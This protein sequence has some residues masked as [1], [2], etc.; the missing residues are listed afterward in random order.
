MENLNYVVENWSQMAVILA[1]IFAPISYFIKRYF[2]FKTKKD[3]ISY[4]LYVNKK[5]ALIDNFTKSSLELERA[6]SHININKVKN[7]LISAD[8]L[9]EEIS[10]PLVEFKKSYS[11]LFLILKKEQM[12][13][14]DLINGNLLD[15]NRFIMDVYLGVNRNREA[16]ISD[17]FFTLTNDGRKFNLEYYSE[18]G[19]SLNLFGL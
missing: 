15:I 18:I 11:M 19:K 1:V 17:D 14:F 13:Y 10:V 3:E 2:D 5:I 4:N 8:E 7:H 16:E 6:Y 12:H 9:D